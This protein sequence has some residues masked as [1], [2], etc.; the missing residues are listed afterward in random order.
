MGVIEMN[1]TATYSPDDNKLRLYAVSR[2]PKDLYERVRATGFIWAPKQ[3]LFVAPMWTPAREDLL[4]ELCEEITDEDSSLVERAEVRA[5][6]FEDYSDK[7]AN[8]AECA[9]KAVSALADG[10]PLGQP[11][12]VGH[13]SER[14]ARK[15]AE[16]IESGMRRAVKMWETSKYWTER[17][18]GAI[19]HAKYLERA[20]VRQR[21]IK[22]LEAELR[23]QE[24]YKA[25][26]EKWLK[27]WNK[28]E[29]T[30]EQARAIANYCHLTVTRTNADGTPNTNGGWRA[31]DVLQPE[32]ERYKA[33]PALTVAD[34]VAAANKAYPRSI[35]HCERW[36]T[37]YNNRLAYERAMLADQGGTA[38]DKFNFEVGGR[39]L[40]RGEWYTIVRVNPGSVGVSGHFANTVTHDEIK[41]YRP[42]TEEQK[43]A[44]TAAMKLP[45]ICNYPGEGFRHMTRAELDACKERKWSDFPKVGLIKATETYGAHRVKRARGVKEWSHVGVYVTDEKRK[46]P[47]TLAPVPKIPKPERTDAPRP[48]Y[49]APERTKF[50]AL[51]DTLKAGVQVVTAPQLF[52]TPLELAERMVELAAIEPGQDVLEPSGGSG[53]ILRAIQTKHP[54]AALVAVEI[55]SHLADVLRTAYRVPTHCKDFLQCNGELG[56]FDRILMNPPFADGADI[57]HIQH[58]LKFLKPGG[59]LVAICADGP[60]QNAKLKP[61]V[62][63]M[64][65]EWEQLP[66]NTFKESGTGVNTV[67]LSVQS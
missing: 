37:H 28:P 59:R 61:I 54:D 5:E 45:P 20:D 13:H 39:V 33:C 47:P 22:K 34:C 23:K 7:R 21:R 10:I 36:I 3:E 31:Y 66:A 2:L 63:A 64:G 53:R 41:D 56:L 49:K 17:A 43:A 48:H 6:R 12:L 14:H 51:R 52:P 9:H 24:R 67:L 50:D 62:E 25:D 1:F 60:R 44:V 65:G 58:A 46:D 18:S 15:D 16:R 4:L 38:A 26:S 35:E 40:R 57:E 27:L 30:L 19:H 55:K 29:L 32:G 42:P 11:I 8:D